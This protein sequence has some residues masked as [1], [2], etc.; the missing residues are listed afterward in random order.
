MLE[1]IDLRELADAQAKARVFLSVYLRN[2]AA[3]DALADRRDAARALLAEDR[4]ARDH[5]AENLKMVEKY[6]RR[7]ADPD[8]GLCVFACFALDFFRAYPVD[9]PTPNLLRVDSSPYILPLATLRDEYENF[10]VVAVDNSAARIF[11]VA[12][13]EATDEQ[14]VRGNIKNH[15][16][17]GGWSQQRY[18]RRRDKQVHRYAGDVVERLRAMEA[19][20]EFDRLLLV[21]SREAIAAVHAA[22]PASLVRRLVGEKA[23]DLGAGDNALNEEIHALFTEAERAAEQALWQRIKA[24]YLA[25]GLAVVGVVDVLGA[26]SEG[27]VAELLVNEGAVA[28]GRRCQ[29]CGKLF[30]D[31][32][33]QCSGCGS[34]DLFPVDTINE[35]VEL[36]EQTGA[37][38]EIAAPIDALAQVGDVAA[39]LRY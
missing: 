31:T 9:A 20:Q 38:V 33:E 8:R 1:K 16:R 28:T 17:K 18:E 32:V 27:R 26:L 22:L 19:D 23:V 6:L 7:E 39:L 12:G 36:A 24:A 35:L 11:V 14:R 10:A 5:F 15:V 21:G 25:G 2:P 37:R 4:E 30:V 3:W 29:G 34:D 13:G